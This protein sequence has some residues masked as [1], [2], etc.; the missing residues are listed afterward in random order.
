MTFEHKKI[1]II[2]EVAAAT[3][4]EFINALDELVSRYS[5]T[6]VQL[7]LSGHS[8]IEATVDLDAIRKQRPVEQLDM[9]AFTAATDKLTWDKSVEDLLEELD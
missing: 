3:R 7:D 8:G 1:R 4:E 6:D 2:R 5:G 9:A